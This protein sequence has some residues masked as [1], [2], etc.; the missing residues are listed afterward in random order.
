V[1]VQGKRAHYKAHI[2]GGTPQEARAAEQALAEYRQRQKLPL[3]TGGVAAMDIAEDVTA[4]G[5]S[6]DVDSGGGGGAAVAAVTDLAE[7][8]PFPAARAPA[9]S[10]P[11]AR[12]T[13]APATAASVPAAPVAP[14]TA[15][16]NENCYICGKVFV[17]GI[18]AHYKVGRW[19]LLLTASCERLD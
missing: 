11:A 3:P 5:G 6:G 14:A 13:T 4:V 19:R 12:A 15:R 9:N 1:F 17:K 2:A 10:A 18:R 8:T 7:A 16:D